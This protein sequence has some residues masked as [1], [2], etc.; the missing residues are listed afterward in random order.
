MAITAIA[1]AA[2][3]AIAFPRRSRGGATTAADAAAVSLARW[4][5]SSAI[6]PEFVREIGRGLPPPRG[7]LREAFL[8]DTI[9]CAGQRRIDRRE[10]R[11]IVLE[12][13]GHHADLGLA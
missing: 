2:A 9:E 12:D 10:R 1:I 11:R 5:L 8:D 6:P 3:M 7:I 13:R 4:R